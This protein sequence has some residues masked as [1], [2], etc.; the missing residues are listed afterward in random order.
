MQF[1][2]NVYMIYPSYVNHL[3][4]SF[5]IYWC[6]S[7]SG[8]SHIVSHD[9]AG[10]PVETIAG[11]HTATAGEPTEWDTLPSDST[12]AAE[13]SLGKA[14]Q[15]DAQSFEKHTGLFGEQGRRDLSQSDARLHGAVSGVGHSKNGRM[16]HA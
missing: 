14:G 8:R 15:S 12:R 9:H 5:A 7:D 6:L 1:K 16:Q 4:Q 13:G 11:S 10:Q 3:I 2:T